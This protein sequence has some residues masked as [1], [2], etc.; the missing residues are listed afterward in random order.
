MN[1]KSLS[2]KKIVSNENINRLDFLYRNHHKW[3]ISVA[4]KVCKDIERAEDLVQELYLY[5]SER[6]DVALY[7]KESFNLQYC[8]A[9]ILS[10]F[11]N[12]TKID[13]RWSELSEQWDTEDTPY[14]TEEDKRL[15]KAYGEVIEEIGKLKKE[16]GW[17]SAMLFELYW[18]SDKTYE[19]L[20]TDIGI[21]KSTA[22]LNTRKVKNILKDRIDNPFKKEE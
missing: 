20:S 19:E 3:L 21:S 4:M 10:R 1:L 15:E 22:F 5:L 7:Y 11:Y 14:D 6:N 8:R 2:N 17:S 12:A 9:F 18:F 16:K 13:K